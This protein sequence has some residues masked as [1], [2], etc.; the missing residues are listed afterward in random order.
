MTE[1]GITKAAIAEK[2]ADVADLT[3]TSAA[4]IVHTVI[5]S[6]VDALQRGEKIELRVPG[7][8]RLRRRKPRKRRNPKTGDRVDVP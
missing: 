1:G 7:N 8:L 3:K 5:G 6:I 2:V 4:I